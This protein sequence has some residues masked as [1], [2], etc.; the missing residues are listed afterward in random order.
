MVEHEPVLVEEALDA[1]AI[2]AHAGAPSLYVDATFGRG[3]H[4]ARI[5]ERLGPEERLLAIDRD[6]AAIAA[7]GARFGA[8]PRVVV[9]GAAFSALASLVEAHGQGRACRGI[10]FD[11]GVSSPQLDDPA[12][13]FSFQADGPLDMRMDTARGESAATWLARAPGDEIRD[14]IRELGEERH[15]GRIARAIVAARGFEPITRTG[16]LAQLV[17]RAVRGRDG[18]KHPATRSFQAIRMHV[19]DELGELRRGLDAAL[20]A[21]VPGG[22]LAVISFHS[23][24]DRM[25][26][27]FMRH[28]SQPDP[29]WARLPLAPDFTPALRAVGKKQRAGDAELQRNPRSRSAIL[30][31]AE[32]LDAPPVKRAA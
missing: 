19:N 21:L 30:R 26:K 27:H 16:Q 17:A 10:L 7:A 25:V 23:L 22:R 12:R 13:G 29:A 5:L 24:E 14:V 18:G 2:T 6:P 15:A 32:R 31:V 3:G 28:Q 11:L 8:E 1:L 4:A 9:V 20:E